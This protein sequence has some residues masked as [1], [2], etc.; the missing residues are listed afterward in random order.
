MYSHSNEKHHDNATE[1]QRYCVDEN[2]FQVTRIPAAVRRREMIRIHRGGF[3]Q[4]RT[5]LRH[6]HSCRAHHRTI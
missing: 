2:P 3:R 5:R 4:V 1:R 6:S